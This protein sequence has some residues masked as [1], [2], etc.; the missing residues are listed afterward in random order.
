MKHLPL[1]IFLA[2]KAIL[3]CTYC[4][5]CY[6]MWQYSITPLLNLYGTWTYWGTVLF[7]SFCGFVS[8]FAFFWMPKPV[9]PQATYDPK[10]G[11]KQA[12][13]QEKYERM[14][15]EEYQDHLNTISPTGDIND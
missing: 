7:L 1:I 9:K 11:T 8:S 6:F 3:L 14:C 13:Q 4:Y 15:H 2:I 10:P 5:I 12:A